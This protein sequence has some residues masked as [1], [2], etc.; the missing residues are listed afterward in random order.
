[1][2]FPKS[3]VLIGTQKEQNKFIGNAVEVTTLR[4]LCEALAKVV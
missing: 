1:M 4:K 3:Y 2:G